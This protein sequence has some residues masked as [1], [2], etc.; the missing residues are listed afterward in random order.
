MPN[1]NCLEGIRCP[2][3]KQEDEVIIGMVISVSVTDDGTDDLAGDRTWDDDSPCACP[4]CKFQGNVKD[5][6]IENQEE[7]SSEL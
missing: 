1:T 2:G 7:P 6:Q 3:C 4:E 5:F